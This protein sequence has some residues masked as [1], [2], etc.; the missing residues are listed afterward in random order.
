MINGKLLDIIACPKC[1]GDV[2]EKD[3]FLLCRKCGLAFPVLDKSIPNMIID[4]SWPVKKAEKN[5]FK[6]ELKL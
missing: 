1:K 2:K 3:M 6:H 4:E 5:K